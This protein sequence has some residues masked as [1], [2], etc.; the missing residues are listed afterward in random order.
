[1]PDKQDSS[2]KIGRDA[3]GVFNTGD[4]FQGKVGDIS[5]IINELPSSSEL[6]KPGIKESLEKLKLAIVSEPNLDEKKKEKALN[7]LQTLAQAAQNDQDED[8]KEQAED[9]MTMLKGIIFGL[10]DA[11]KLVEQCQALLPLIAKMFGLG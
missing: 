6:N 1:M 9:A 8:S 11:A 4:N 10:P 7:Q 3:T 5:K 2:I